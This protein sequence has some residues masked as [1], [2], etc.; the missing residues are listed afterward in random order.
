MII[1]IVIVVVVVVIFMMMRS[2]CQ[3]SLPDINYLD[4]DDD[5]GLSIR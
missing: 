5:D 4:T 2:S 3:P 1:I